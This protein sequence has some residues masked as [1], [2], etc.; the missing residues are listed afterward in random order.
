MQIETAKRIP[1][2]QI[3][4][5]LNLYPTKQTEK[6]SW[7]LSPLRNEKTA[8]FHVHNHKNLWFDFGEGKGGDTISLVQ[9][10]LQQLGQDNSVSAA[11]KW[12]DSAID[13]KIDYAPQPHMN[14]KNSHPP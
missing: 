9:A 11:L 7:Y 13:G 6:E 5:K 4:A 1:L 2:A 10:I 14:R 8:S 12:L 3:L